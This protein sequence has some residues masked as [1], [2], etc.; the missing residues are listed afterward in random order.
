MTSGDATPQNDAPTPETNAGANETPQGNDSAK[1][2]GGRSRNGFG[3]G[4]N[5][6]YYDLSD[7][8]FE[9][10]TPEIGCVLGLRSERMD[11]KVQFDT[12]REKMCDYIAKNLSSPMDVMPYVK[13][14]KDPYEDFVSEHLPTD[15]TPE[16]AGST[17]LSEIFKQK[18]K[19]YGDR[20]VSFKS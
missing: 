14:L 10:D 11:K 7:K 5:N 19:K 4:R 13:D 17:A 18:I 2:S 3:K 20:K 8:L 9:G 12:F 1:K 16:Q 6:N 15:L